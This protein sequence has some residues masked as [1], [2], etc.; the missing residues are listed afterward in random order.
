MDEFVPVFQISTHLMNI[1]VF[2][3]TVDLAGGTAH[4]IRPNVQ[5]S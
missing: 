2:Q 5:G 1:R 3:R 4:V